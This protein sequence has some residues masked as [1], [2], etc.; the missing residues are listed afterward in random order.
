[1]DLNLGVLLCAE[2]R[3]NVSDFRE[4]VCGLKTP[5]VFSL[6]KGVLEK[7]FLICDRPTCGPATT[8][9]AIQEGEKIFPHLFNEGGEIGGKVRI[10]AYTGGAGKGYSRRE[11]EEVLLQ[12]VNSENK[13]T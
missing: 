7:C 12:L 5:A 2:G 6:A 3:E 8:L 9:F 1:M 10:R 11:A 4:N 13:L